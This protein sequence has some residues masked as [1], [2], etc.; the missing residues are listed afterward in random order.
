[1]TMSDQAFDREK[2]KFIDAG[3]RKTAV[4]TG[5]YNESTGTIDV[6]DTAPAMFTTQTVTLQDGITGT[7]VSAAVDVSQY[8][9][10]TIQGVAAGTHTT[11][12]QASVDGTNYATL[13]DDKFVNDISG[14]MSGSADL[15][16]IEGK[17]KYLRVNTT[18]VSGALTVTLI[19]GN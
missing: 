12:I 16:S 2:D 13:Q 3:T 7:A 6:T 9:N 17:F 19:S 14:G 1:M 11:V 18:A 8:Y 15:V 10:H 4:R 5:G